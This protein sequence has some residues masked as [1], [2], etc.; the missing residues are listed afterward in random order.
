[1]ERRSNSIPVLEFF[2]YINEAVEMGRFSWKDKNRLARLKLR[3]VARAFYSTQP[4]LRAD[5]TY[6]EFRIA[7]ANRFK[8][9]H[10]NQYR[11]ARVQSA[12]QEKNESP[13]EFL[14]RLQILCQRT[15][16]SSDNPVEQAVINQEAE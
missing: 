6:E 10:T 16:R 12:P 2:E 8:D 15:I 9:K 3:S 4:Q 5:V 11:Y 1:M 14:D 7:F 13:D